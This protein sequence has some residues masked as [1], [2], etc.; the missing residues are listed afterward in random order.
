M[1]SLA[2]LKRWVV[3]NDTTEEPFLSQDKNFAANTEL[4]GTI[5]FAN[6]NAY[7][8]LSTQNVSVSA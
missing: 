6:N 5:T 4:I 2:K 7:K 8:F 1:K 3:L